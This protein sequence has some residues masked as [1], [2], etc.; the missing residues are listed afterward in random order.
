MES[1]LQVRW[2]IGDDEFGNESER[3]EM[4]KRDW[5]FPPQ[6]CVSSAPRV[7]IGEYY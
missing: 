7:F 2:V 6:L 3:L 5:Q 1:R 4:Y